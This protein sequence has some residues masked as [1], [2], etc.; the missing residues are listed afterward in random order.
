M[1]SKTKLL[2][3][4][5]FCA[6]LALLLVMGADAQTPG[7]PQYPASLNT[8]S[9]LLDASNNAT[10]NL[11]GGINSSATTITVGA[12]AAFAT[13]GAIT[14]DSEI[15]IYTGKTSTT[16]TGC[17]RGS[18]STTA[19]SHS[20]GAAVR[21]NILARHM[22][23]RGEAIIALET[24][25]G[26]GS[27][28]PTNGTILKGTGTG[29][30]AWGQLTITPSV[31]F[32]IGS[33]TAASGNTFRL[34]VS[35]ESDK[36]AIRYNG[37]VWEFSNDGTTFQSVGSGGNV[38]GTGASGQFA[39][40]TGSN[41]LSTTAVL[42]LSGGVAVASSLGVTNFMSVGST[43][44]PTSTIGIL[45]QQT[46]GG[47]GEGI[48]SQVSL[49]GGAGSHA[50]GN[51]IYALLT[52]NST[53]NQTSTLIGGNLRVQHQGTG[54]ANDVIA[55]RAY[56][57]HLTNSSASRFIG[58]QSWIQHAP[59][60]G[61]SSTDVYYYTTAGAVAGTVTNV[62]LANLANP[63]TS[64]GT[65]ANYTILDVDNAD[66]A[67]ATTKRAAYFHG[68]NIRLDETYI[69]IFTKTVAPAVGA[70]GSLRMWYNGTK[71]RCS[72]NGGAYGD[73]F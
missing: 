59:T 14:I 55:V 29:T 21:Q 38:N 23:A 20:S 44:S 1:N 48:N 64:S 51:G 56:A 69:D 70:S 73:C 25:I 67:T 53:G 68:G 35:S 4:F 49:A 39:Y 10:T 33:G 50:G 65:I 2:M 32:T 28:T 41:T 5:L 37:T 15:I 3:T 19:A 52:N 9:T 46:F 30:S 27:S 72:Y 54:S 31:D 13:T 18:F 7:T 63:T 8:Q 43:V 71:L 47:T 16:F 66:D 61:G 26:T 40:W 24:K 45:Q 57:A 22:T 58:V 60:G 42:S 34:M 17:T 11:N 12:T 62:R 36:P 6:A